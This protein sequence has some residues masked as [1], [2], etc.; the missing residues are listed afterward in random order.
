MKLLNKIKDVTEDILFVDV[1]VEKS[2]DEVDN[3][4]LSKIVEKADNTI[5]ISAE[6]EEEF[7]AQIEEAIKLRKAYNNYNE[8]IV[9]EEKPKKELSDGAWKFWATV[10]SGVTSGV[11]V[12]YSTL[13]AD[14]GNFINDF[15]KK[16][17]NKKIDGD[18]F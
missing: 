9:K 4:V 12:I 13:Y 3:L 17:I 2:M 10:V 15:T 11:I 6:T 1:P 5:S 14:E 18:K 16:V 8:V 7:K